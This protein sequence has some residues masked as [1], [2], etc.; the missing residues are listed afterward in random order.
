MLM[1]LSGP[2]CSTSMT[3]SVHETPNLSPL[4][5][6][7]YKNT[8]FLDALHSDI[9]TLSTLKYKGFWMDETLHRII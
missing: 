8:Y 3:L 9:R 7:I 6:K 4:Y 1:F 5:R 2:M